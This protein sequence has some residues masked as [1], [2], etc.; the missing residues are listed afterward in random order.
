MVIQRKADEHPGSCQTSNNLRDLHFMALSSSA[1]RN[2]SGLFYQKDE[3]R[4]SIVI[5]YWVIIVLALPLWWTT[6]SIQRLR[7]PSRQILDESRK[8][9]QLPVT[10]CLESQDMRLVQTV[11]HVL[12]N[13]ASEDPSRWRGILVDVVGVSDCCAWFPRTVVAAPNFL[14]SSCKRQAALYIE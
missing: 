13:S 6:T 3:L 14:D 8:S 7:L 10:I 5:A 12:T 2:P 11:K 4:R 9:L 1:L